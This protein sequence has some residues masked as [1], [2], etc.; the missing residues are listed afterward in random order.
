VQDHLVTDV[1]GVMWRINGIVGGGGQGLGDKAG[2]WHCGGHINGV[3]GHGGWCS[4]CH[5]GDKTHKRCWRV[6]DGMR[7]VVWVTWRV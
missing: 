4:R 7:D 1:I 3:V 6:V 5:L 2:K